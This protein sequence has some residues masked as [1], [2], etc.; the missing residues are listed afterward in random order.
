M[1]KFCLFFQN[2]FTFKL[3]SLSV[4]IACENLCDVSLTVA[5]F[6]D[7]DAGGR[8]LA[9]ENVAAMLGR[10]HPAAHGERVK[11]AVAFAEKK[12]FADFA[13][14]P[15]IGYGST[16]DDRI[17]VAVE[18]TEKRFARHLPRITAG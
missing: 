5:G 8:K 10:F 13:P 17:P 3:L 15:D 9:V 4:L 16:F 2:F 11:I 1:K 6:G 12:I 18:M 14:T 7:A